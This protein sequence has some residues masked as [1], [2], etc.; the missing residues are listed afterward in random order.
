M[1]DE[2]GVVQPPAED[3]VVVAVVVRG[4]AQLVVPRARHEH[5]GEEFK[6]LVNELN[7]LNRNL[8]LAVR[9]QHG[10]QPGEQRSVW[11]CG[12]ARA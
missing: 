2:E 1:D 3:G 5:L 10:R 11:V 4:G 12:N 6:I 8:C 9:G 7:L